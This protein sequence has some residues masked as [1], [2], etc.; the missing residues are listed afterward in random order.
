MIEYFLRLQLKSRLTV[1]EV[2][3]DEL[4]EYEEAIYV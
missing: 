1:R 4:D 3:Y 2:L